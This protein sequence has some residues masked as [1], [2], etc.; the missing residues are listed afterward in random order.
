MIFD[1]I[2]AGNTIM[3][4]VDVGVGFIL[5]FYLI[6]YH[7]CCLFHFAES[8]TYCHEQSALKLAAYSLQAEN[9]D[10]TSTDTQQYFY[11]ENYLPSKVNSLT[12]KNCTFVN[13]LQHMQVIH[14]LSIQV[15]LSILPEMHSQL[16]G[17][18]REIA[19][20][21]YL[22]EVQTLPEYGMVFYE[23]AKEKKE[24]VGSFLLGLSVRGLVVYNVHRGTK[25]PTSH[26]PWKRIKNLS[27]V[28]SN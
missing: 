13:A 18:N 16:K 1:I 15:I 25:T 12:L 19:E 22:K 6:L 21:H 24:K 9:G 7:T 11:I 20:L 14:K 8:K 23:V 27:F 2:Q 26:W 3:C 4:E 17:Q 10:K 28:V 5:T